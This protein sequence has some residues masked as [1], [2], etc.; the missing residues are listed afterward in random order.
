MTPTYEILFRKQAWK[1]LLEIQEPYRRKISERI[2]GLKS[3]PRPSGIEKIRGFED[4]YRIRIGPY[5]VVYMI[6]DDKLIVKVI[7]IGARKDVYRKL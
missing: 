6:Q 3:N 7:R 5:R 1:Q 4:H 2:D